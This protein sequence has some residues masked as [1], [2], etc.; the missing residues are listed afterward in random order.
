MHVSDIPPYYDKDPFSLHRHFGFK[1]FYT[2]LSL[3]DQSL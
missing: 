2:V 3:E 1:L